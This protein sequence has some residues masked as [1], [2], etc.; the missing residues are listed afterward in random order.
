MTANSWKRGI[1]FNKEK[2]LKETE[3]IE[4]TKQNFRTSILS[5]L[6][7]MLDDIVSIN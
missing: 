4:K 6:R 7:E 5:I 1:K 2:I 3:S